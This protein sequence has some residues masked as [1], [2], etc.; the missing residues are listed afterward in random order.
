MASI[1]LKNVGVDF[2]LY[3]ASARSLKKTVFHTAVGGLIGRSSSLAKPSIRALHDITLSLGHGD[4]LGLVGPNG[5]GKTTLLRVLGGVYHPTAGTISIEGMR[6]PL[7]DLNVGLD[8]EAT[9]RETL[10]LRGLFLGLSRK[11]V[12]RRS[13][14]IAEFSGLGDYLDFPVRTYSSGMLLRLLFS[15]AVAIEADILLMDEWI[16]IGDAEFRERANRRLHQNIDR[17]K[18]LV[19]ASHDFDM[20][21]A[22][23]NRAVYLEAGAIIAQ[24]KVDDVL[25]QYVNRTR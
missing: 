6:V 25:E 22:L 1:D 11:E 14:E 20:L 13:A 8:D 15:V 5:A 12:D 7:F 23:C 2:V 18:I 19:F 10:M 17:S 3:E 24:G 4:R 21:R 9:G 16:G